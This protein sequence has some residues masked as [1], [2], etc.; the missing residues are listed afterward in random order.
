M[1][2]ARDL[3]AR[4]RP[5]GAPGAAAPAGV[6]VDRVAELDREL[7]PI[8]DALAAT[9]LEA[10]R[11]RTTA[12]AEARRRTAAAEEEARAIVDAAR[13]DA[14][15]RRAEA[16]AAILRQGEREAAASRSAA[17]REAAGLTARAQ[18]RLPD[19]VAQV[20]DA[21]R[22]TAEAPIGSAAP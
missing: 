14:E 12:A 18:H 4:F 11:I 3:L 7:Q 19:L 10:V 5:V 1:P 17:E 16:A 22:R 2:R 6:P 8:F 9:E 15:V 21:V 13:R 20:V